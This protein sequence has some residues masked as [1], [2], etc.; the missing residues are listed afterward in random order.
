M[1]MKQAHMHLK[2]SNGNEAGTHAE[3]AHD[4]LRESSAGIL[5]RP[6]SVSG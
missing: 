3:R 6:Y 4:P 1:E 2:T 5:L